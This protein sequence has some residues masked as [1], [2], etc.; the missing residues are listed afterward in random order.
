[1][2]SPASE[3][4]VNIVLFSLSS[5]SLLLTNKLLLAALPLPSLVAVFQFGA[6]AAWVLLLQAL[7][8]A[9]PEQLV[10]S[11]VRQ[12]LLY[13][14]FF[15]SAIFCNMQAL[16]AANGAASS[17]G[18]AKRRGARAERTPRTLEPRAYL[19]WATHRTTRPAPTPAPSP[20][21]ALRRRTLLSAAYA[22]QSSTGTKMQL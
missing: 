7:G 4:V 19:P 3:L 2:S 17:G 16:S 5:S 1:M 12:Y 22:K 18:M 14:G 15:V 13:V 10:W 11:R 21:N 9:E 6:T 20:Q 8:Y